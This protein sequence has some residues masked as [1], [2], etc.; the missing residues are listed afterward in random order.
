MLIHFACQ[1]RQ[2]QFTDGL[3]DVNIARAGHRAV[4]GGVTTRQPRCF[5]DDL[6]AFRGGFVAAIEDE[7]MRG[8]QGGRAQI[9]IAAPERWAG[10]GAGCA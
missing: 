2:L 10:S 3:R 4:I 7:A 9:I 8:D 6:Q 1:C 5:A